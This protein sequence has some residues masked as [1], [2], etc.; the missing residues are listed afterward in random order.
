M[1]QTG[2][3][4]INVNNSSKWTHTHADSYALAVLASGAKLLS[5]LQISAPFF[6]IFYGRSTLFS[7]TVARC[8]FPQ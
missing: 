3:I 4:H 2:R 7:P 6:T 1:L 5:L 8:V